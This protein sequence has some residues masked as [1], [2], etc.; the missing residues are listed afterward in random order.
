MNA[1]KRFLGDEQRALRVLVDASV[2]LMTVGLAV[3]VG[4]IFLMQ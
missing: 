3:A 1:L 2:A 4:A